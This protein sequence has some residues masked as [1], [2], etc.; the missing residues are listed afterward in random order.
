[1]SFLDIGPAEGKNVAMAY[2]RSVYGPADLCMLAHLDLLVLMCFILWLCW[3]QVN[4]I[5]I[6]ADAC[7]V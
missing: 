1:M 3:A 7:T 4:D 6:E 2:P 5:L